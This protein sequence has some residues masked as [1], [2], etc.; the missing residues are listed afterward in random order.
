M[1][2]R[3][4]A[5]RSITSKQF[6]I[7]KLIHGASHT[8]AP[9]FPLNQDRGRGIRQGTLS[10]LCSLTRNCMRL[11][12]WFSDQFVL[13]D[14]ELYACI[15]FVLTSSS[16]HTDTDTDTATVTD[17]D[18][19]TDT[20]TPACEQQLCT[21]RG[22]LRSAETACPTCSF[23]VLRGQR[24]RS[25]HTHIHTH[26]HTHTQRADVRP[27]VSHMKYWTHCGDTIQDQIYH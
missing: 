20:D 10:C 11:F 19:D 13:I 4:R 26:T 15:F 16:S 17:T 14:Q 22:K 3:E 12:V 27:M 23:Q 18:T 7:S 5:R 21:Q 6:R 25:K 9:S 8:R 24:C 2:E 1:R